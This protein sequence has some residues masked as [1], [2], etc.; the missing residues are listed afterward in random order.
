MAWNV[1]VC[2]CGVS[3][4]LACACRGEDGTAPLARSMIDEALLCAVR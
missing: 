3:V 2:K 4:C 1:L